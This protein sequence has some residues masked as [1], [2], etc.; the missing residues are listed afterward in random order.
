MI[1]DQFCMFFDHDAAA[2]SA[3]SRAV[4]VSPFAGRDEPLNITVVLTGAGNATMNVKVQESDDQ[5]GG[6]ADV[7]SFG[8]DK[9]DA[10][11]AVL[12]IALPRAVKKKF[13]RLSYTLTGTPAGLKVFAAVTRDHIAPYAPGQFIDRGKVQG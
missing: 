6:F 11:G 12:P 3:D 13:I 2:A 7:G 1:L 8:L 9:V 4:N 5:A 10:A